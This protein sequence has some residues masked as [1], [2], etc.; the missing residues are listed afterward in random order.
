MSGLY[1]DKGKHFRLNPMRSNS[2]TCPFSTKPLVFKLLLK[3]ILNIEKEHKILCS[4]L[5]YLCTFL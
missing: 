2:K 3:K 4:L 1:E 5:Y